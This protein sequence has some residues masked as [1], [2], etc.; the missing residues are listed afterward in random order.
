MG[1]PD[2]EVL[3]KRQQTYDDYQQKMTQLITRLTDAANRSR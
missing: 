3:E 2:A 1:H